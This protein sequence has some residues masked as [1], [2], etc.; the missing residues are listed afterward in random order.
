MH[1]GRGLA[2]WEVHRGWELAGVDAFF[3][4]VSRQDDIFFEPRITEVA[5]VW[6]EGG[7]SRWD[8][9]PTVLFFFC[10]AV[11]GDGRRSGGLG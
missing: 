7:G 6:G 5:L 1:R 4:E 11:G 2:G 10:G 9:K 8:L 3:A